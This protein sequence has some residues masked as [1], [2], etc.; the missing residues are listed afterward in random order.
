MRLW[1]ETDLEDLYAYAKTDG[2][3]KRAGWCSY[4]I[5][6]ES[7]KVMSMFISR[8]RFVPPPIKHD[9]F[10]NKDG[11]YRNDTLRFRLIH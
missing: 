10:I 11:V 1:K 5:I 8:K 3:G 4:K 9:N 7:Q 6:K 2:V